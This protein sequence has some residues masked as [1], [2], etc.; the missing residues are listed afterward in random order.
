MQEF[1]LS[2]A[3]KLPED[4]FERAAHVILCGKLKA[5]VVKL[6]EELKIAGNVG[7]EIV[8]P[9]GP[10][11]AKLVPAA[12]EADAAAGDVH[13]DKPRGHATPLRVA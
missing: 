2:T 13:P 1:R 6:M 10:N 9:R 4:E 11:A 5:G 3:I 8:T 12:P 7:H